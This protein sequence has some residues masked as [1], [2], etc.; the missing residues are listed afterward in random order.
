MGKDVDQLTIEKSDKTNKI[1]EK[2]ETL[3]IN[4]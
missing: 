1:V 4:R 2:C 3:E